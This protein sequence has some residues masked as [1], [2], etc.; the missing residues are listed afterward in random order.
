MTL[1]IAVD[2]PWRGRMLDRAGLRRTIAPAILAQA[3]GWSIGPFVGY[4]PLL[5]I[6][7]L[8]GLMVVP[9]WAVIRQSIMAATTP[10]PRK[11]ALSLDS[12][13]TELAFMVGPAAG[14]WLAITWDTRWA[15]LTFQLA[16]VAGGVVLVVGRPAAAGWR[17]VERA[18]C[19][20][21]RDLLRHRQGHRRRDV[22]GSGADARRGR[23]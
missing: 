23:Q 6:S 20:L 8:T 16:G 21:N 22:F 15:L 10:P 11:P 4:L 18:A 5:A 19:W 13:L 1:A 2:A 17:G 3:V 9:V 12:S 7:A 14:A